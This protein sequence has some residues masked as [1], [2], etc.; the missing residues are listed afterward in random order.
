VCKAAGICLK[1]PRMKFGA[2]V[3]PFRWVPPYEHNVRRIAK[4]GFK[5]V[6]LI[7]WDRRVLDEYYTPK[8]IKDLGELLE[9]LGLELT[10]F[11]STP[12]GMAS[13][14]KEDKDAAVE[15][16]RKLVEVASWFGTKVVNTVS[17]WPFET[18]PPDI[19]ERPLMQVFSCDIRYDQDMDAVWES[20]VNLMRK[21]AD[22]VED[23]GLRYAI[24]PHPFRLVSNVDGMLRLVDQVG[25]KAIGMNW[26]PSHLFPSG[27]T[28]AVGILR[29]KDL[30]FHTHISDNDAMTNC[31]W[32]PGTGKIDWESVLRA[33]KAVGY[34]HVLSLELED[35]PGASH[36]S[37][38]EAVSPEF[39]TE[40]LK[41]MGYFG[42]IARN[43]GINIDT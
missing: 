30:V 2:C 10:E 5:G 7:A 11:V 14:R 35:A 22:V 18:R 36:G 42:E 41:A 19:K 21:F 6:E 17:P 34:N 20:Y 24:E 1:V 37:V 27:E 31:H 39:D 38:P 28:P 13:L 4:L 15:H 43:I 12:R 9:S 29:L 25:S 3:W 32:R 33:L 23:A 40:N 26:D 8:R 16:F